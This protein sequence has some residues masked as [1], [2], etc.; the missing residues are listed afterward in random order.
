MF[1]NKNTQIVYCSQSLL[2][3]QFLLRT[4]CLPDVGD[5]RLTHAE[6]HL[7]EWFTILTERNLIFGT[8]IRIVEY[9]F[10]QAPLYKSQQVQLAGEAVVFSTTV[11]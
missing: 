10:Q 5:L 2:V 1:V 6:R 4:L 11:R 7:F 3:K 8:T 9:R